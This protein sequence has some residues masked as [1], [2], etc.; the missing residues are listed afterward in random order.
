MF[1]TVGA[2]LSI[3]A[4]ILSYLLK[5]KTGWKET[6]DLLTRLIRF[7]FASQL[8][9]TLIAIGLAVEYSIKV[10]VFSNETTCCMLERGC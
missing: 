2:D 3:T 5:S 7:T 8:P 6:D 9:P 4:I 1:C 10:I